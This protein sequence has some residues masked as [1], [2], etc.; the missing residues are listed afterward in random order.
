MK[1]LDTNVCVA[2]LNGKDRKLNRRF[3][4]EFDALSLCSVVK[5]ELLFGAR[6]SARVTENLNA[7]QKL[8]GAL[9]SL[10][11]DDVA[12]AQYGIA[13]AQL[14]AAGTPIGPNDL[15]IAAIALAQDAVVVTRNVSE[16]SRVPTLQV[17]PW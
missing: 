13:R 9:P 14:R 1:I 7:L 8:F 10:P 5:A 3:T 12:A 17:E 15:M 4:Q 16:F 11:F 2:V 6:A